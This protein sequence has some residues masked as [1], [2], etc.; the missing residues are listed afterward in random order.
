MTV[1]CLL[2]FIW[3]VFQASCMRIQRR[4]VVAESWHW[5]NERLALAPGLICVLPKCP[6]S[7]FSLEILMPVTSTTLLGVW[8]LRD[9]YENSLFL[10][11]TP[12]FY[13]IHKDCDFRGEIGEVSIKRKKNASL[14]LTGEKSPDLPCEW[15]S[16]PQVCSE[17]RWQWWVWKKSPN[18][19]NK[20]VV[21][22]AQCDR[23]WGRGGHGQEGVMRGY[24]TFLIKKKK[25][26]FYRLYLNILEAT[27]KINKILS[28][29]S[30]Q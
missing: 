6:V 11:F 30:S 10:S 16:W 19:E 28:L 23:T 8:Q 5:N 29:P 21:R 3:S 13:S 20:H 2:S 18:Q 27:E 14:R 1:F 12:T 17:H 24:L 7:P 26:R 4:T 9:W 25:I 15:L 22:W